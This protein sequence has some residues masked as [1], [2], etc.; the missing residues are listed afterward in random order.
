MSHSSARQ[1]RGDA[2][3]L[4]LRLTLLLCAAALAGVVAMSLWRV[5][6]GG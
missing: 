4:G 3:L 2:V 6:A 5:L 1:R